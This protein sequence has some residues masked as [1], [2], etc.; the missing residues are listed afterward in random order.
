MDTNNTQQHH[1]SQDHVTHAERT[2]ILLTTTAPRGMR[3][4]TNIHPQITGTT[5][6][7][8]MRPARTALRGANAMNP[9][10]RDA[11]AMNLSMRDANAMNLSMSTEWKHS[12]IV[13]AAMTTTKSNHNPIEGLTKIF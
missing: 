10:M 13:P 7:P 4:V 12:E 6:A 3:R 1:V 2:T 5:G 11:N 9:S 8:C